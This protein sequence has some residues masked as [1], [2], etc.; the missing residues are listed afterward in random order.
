MK[1]LTLK[2]E[3]LQNLKNEVLQELH[4]LLKLDVNTKK[5]IKKV[6]SGF[7]DNDITEFWIGGMSNS[8]ICDYVQMMS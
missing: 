8:E 4:E 6:K 1:K 5:A 3:V 7:F 2:D